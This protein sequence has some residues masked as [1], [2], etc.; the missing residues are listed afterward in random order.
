MIVGISCRQRQVERYQS[1][2]MQ[3]AGQII[4]TPYLGCPGPCSAPAPR[5]CQSWQ[6]TLSISDVLLGK[7]LEK[8]TLAPW[9]GR[10]ALGP[11][12]LPTASWSF[13]C[14][15]RLDPQ[16]DKGSGVEHYQCWP[17]RTFIPIFRHILVHAETSESNN[18][19]LG[20]GKE[21]ASFSQPVAAHLSLALDLTNSRGV[22]AICIEYK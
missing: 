15:R 8:P 2:A 7:L 9:S 19:D 14:C 4:A 1:E 18:E 5:G 21:R 22:E 6:V 13:P 3:P 20:V 17:T 10:S 16:D 11:K 12:T